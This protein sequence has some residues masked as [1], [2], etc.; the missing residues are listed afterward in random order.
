MTVHQVRNGRH[1]LRFEGVVLASASSQRDD[2][3]RW[4]E[5]VVYGLANGSYVRSKIGYSLIA[6][7]AECPLVDGKM[8]RWLDLDDQTESRAQRVPCVVCQ[9]VLRAGALDPMMMVE[10]TRYTATIARDPAHLAELLTAQ[11][12]R[13]SHQLPRL[14][15]RVVDQVCAQDPDFAQYWSSVSAVGVKLTG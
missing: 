14:V 1:I 3:P 7:R 12:G 8:E 4:S 5:L 15:S 11:Q 6:H 9:P 10:S 2:A 13:G